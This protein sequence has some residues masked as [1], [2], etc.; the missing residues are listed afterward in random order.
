MH[1]GL[2]V[3]DPSKV[4]LRRIVRNWFLLMIFLAAIQPPMSP[5]RG[6]PRKNQ[7]TPPVVLC[8]D[9]VLVL[10]L[11][12]LEDRFTQPPRLTCANPVIL[13]R[14]SI[15]NPPNQPPQRFVQRALEFG[16]TL[17]F[18]VDHRWK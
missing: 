14:L 8:H 2:H 9:D 5:Y 1:A 11:T 10:W 6:I 17:L 4:D 16:V 18:G 15:F 12:C 3:K 7:S 13:S